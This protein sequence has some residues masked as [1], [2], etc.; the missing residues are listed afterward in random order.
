MATAE[1]AKLILNLYE[2]RREPTMRK[3]RD[4]VVLGFHP[5]SPEDIWK[6]FSDTDHPEYNAYFRMV[7][8]Y[9]DM[10]AALVNKGALDS[11]LFFETCGELLGI[12]SKVEDLHPQLSSPQMMGPGFMANVKKF[13]DSRPE[14]PER[15]AFIKQRF[16]ELAK[17]FAASQKATT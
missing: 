16:N 1:D 12:W 3:A 10:A 11:D 9:W 5:Q 14:A 17:R 13:I 7:T 6:L 8:S 4:W 2:L 15:V